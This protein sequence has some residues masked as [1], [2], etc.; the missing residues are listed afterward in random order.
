MADDE[1]AEEE[2]AP[3]VELGEREPVEGQPL[4]RVASRLTWPHEKSRVIEKEG[5]SVIRTPDGP[6]SLA[7]VL[8]DVDVTYFD[9]RQSFVT[10]VTAAAGDAP[11]QTE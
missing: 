7:D 11:V 5:G 6:Q 2:E 1:D 9:T 8:A 3:A 10:A 4:A